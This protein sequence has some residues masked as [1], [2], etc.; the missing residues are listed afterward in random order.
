MLKRVMDLILTLLALL[1]TWPL[2]LLIAL[3]VWIS[4]KGPIVFVQQR[5]GQGGRPFRMVKFRTMR[6]GVDPY[7][8]SPREGSDP[9]LTCIGRWLRETS[10]DELPQLLNVLKGDMSLVGPRPLYVS[11]IGEWNVDQRQRLLAKPGL[12]GLAQTRGRG[13]LTREEK[14]ALDVMYVQ[15]QSLILDLRLIV[16][17]LWQVCARRAIYERQYSQTAQTRP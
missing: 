1:L 4:S 16:R 7:G 17:T 6:T 14:L 9:R 10:L 8:P 3:A 11:Q 12:T 2:M 15:N 5:A 13:K